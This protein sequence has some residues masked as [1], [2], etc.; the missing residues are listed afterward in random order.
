[1]ALFDFNQNK[2]HKQ[3]QH[4]FSEDSSCRSPDPLMEDVD[5]P[6]GAGK[7]TPPKDFVC[8]ITTHIFNDPVTLE[9]GQTYERRA[10]Q[11]WIDRGNSNC[12]ITRQKLNGTQL[13]KTNYV[14]KRL[15]A[16]WQE[17][18]QSSASSPLSE[19]VRE[20][21]EDNK[22][23]PSI[24]SV[25][26]NSVISQANI[27]ETMSELRH[28]IS[29]VCTSEILKEAESA[30][31]KIQQF[32]KE[33]NV[34]LEM[35]SMLSKPPV[36]NGFVEILFN[37]VDTKVL[38]ATV[39]LLTELGSRDE[40]VIQMLTRVD[41]DVECIIELFKKGLAEAAALVFLLKPVTASLVEMGIVDHLLEMLG[42]REGDDDLLEICVKPKTASLFLLGDII[43]NSSEESL[44]GTVR[45]IISTNAINNIVE[46]LRAEEVKERSAAVSILLTCILEEGKCRNIVAENAELSPVVE[47]FTGLNDVE[48]FEMVHFLSEL[49]KLNRYDEP[50]ILQ[51]LPLTNKTYMFHLNSA[52][53]T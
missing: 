18:N 53:G 4:L 25:S 29:D 23:K 46:S 45:S 48:Q 41:S 51:L 32:W 16:S 31:L 11:E 34:E 15:I 21:D 37:S 30:V 12:P 44:S 39:L 3:K 9:T 38:K 19:V 50:S 7:R 35:R 8:P 33:A 10:I 5:N 28:A 20:V 1:M 26:P 27:N 43:R 17:K 49:V 13:P 22:F 36:V 14:L 2:S 42:N 40:N 6:P 52:G 47:S 24:L